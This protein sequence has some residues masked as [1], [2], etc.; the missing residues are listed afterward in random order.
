MF[1]LL[2]LNTVVNGDISYAIRTYRMCSLNYIVWDTKLN[3]LQLIPSI[4]KAI[5]SCSIT[6]GRKAALEFRSGNDSVEAVE[7][8]LLSVSILS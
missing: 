7:F 1:A 6:T 3:A 2:T 8:L 4:I 5:S